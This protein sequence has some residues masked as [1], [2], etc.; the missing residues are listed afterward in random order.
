MWR[1]PATMKSHLQFGCIA[2]ALAALS[3]APS[4]G[5]VPLERKES[6]AAAADFSSRIYKATIE[7]HPVIIVELY[8]ISLQD[9]CIPRSVAEDPYSFEMHIE[10]RKGSTSFEYQK[11]GFIPPPLS[12]DV[13]V[14]S[15]ATLRQHYFLEHRF[16]LAGKDF[17]KMS[18]IM[19]SIEFYYRRC[20]EPQVLEYRSYWRPV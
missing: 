20:R 1:T 12:G 4:N 9:L 3:C 6:P 10:L 17:I 18:D 7:N 5:V 11:G 2:V 14:A 13:Q 19:A 8:N 15:R 16:N